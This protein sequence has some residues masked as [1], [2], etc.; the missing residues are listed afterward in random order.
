MEGMII[1]VIC[2]VE[3][4]ST[5]HG[6]GTS[7]SQVFRRLHR[8]RPTDTS[9]IGSRNFSV[10]GLQLWNNLPTEIRMRG[11]TSEHY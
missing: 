7:T 4:L 9:Q 10:A 5:C 1:S 8:C 3:R 6:H 11:T 2:T